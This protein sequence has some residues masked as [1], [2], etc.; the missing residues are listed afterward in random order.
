M[1][2]TSRI[3][4]TA[5]QVRA[6]LDG[7]LREVWVPIEPQP[8]I[9]AD[10]LRDVPHE[11]RWYAASATTNEIGTEYRPL[12][13]DLQHEWESPFGPP[14]TELWCA[15]EWCEHEIDDIQGTRTFYRADKETVRIGHFVLTWNNAESM[16]R[17]LS[18][19][20]LRTLSSEPRRVESITFDEC[21]ATGIRQAASV[22]YGNY[23]RDT[24]ETFIEQWKSRHPNAEWA[25]RG[26]VEVKGASD[27]E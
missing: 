6:A 11:N 2:T 12:G 3:I 17:E 16:P 5:E 19:L 27:G 22:P 20:T 4:L 7:R 24:I 18:R 14:G 23:Q 13:S 9:Q 10:A 25:W 26:V 21:A 1:T 15:E 8:P